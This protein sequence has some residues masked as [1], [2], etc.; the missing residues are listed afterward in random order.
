MPRVD[1]PAKV[2]G[3]AVFGLDVRVPGMLFAVIAHCPYFGGRLLRF[4]DC[5]A[6]TI[7][8]VKAIFAAPPSVLFQQSN[9]I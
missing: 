1:T 2:D 8:G 4:D 3:S 5:D 9:A 7:P 6:K